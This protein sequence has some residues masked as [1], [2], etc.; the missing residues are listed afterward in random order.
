MVMLLKWEE[1][2]KQDI[3]STFTFLK[4]SLC[5]TFS[6]ANT[7]FPFILL[8]WNCSEWTT[9]CC[10]SQWPLLRAGLRSLGACDTADH[11]VPGTTSSPC[12][13]DTPLPQFFSY[14]TGLLSV[15]FTGSSSITLHMSV[16]QDTHSPRLFCPLSSLLEEFIQSWDFKYYPRD[17]EFHMY[18]SSKSLSW[19]DSLIQP[20]LQLHPH[21]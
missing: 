8:H 17:V 13:Q 6:R 15:S 21:V 10:R 12:F 18:I 2:Q 5:F 19:T 4:L 9:S 16:L 1:K 11:S 3:N 20:L 14:H 7:A